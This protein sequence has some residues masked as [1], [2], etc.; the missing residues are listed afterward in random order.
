MLDISYP[1]GLAEDVMG[2]RQLFSKRIGRDAALSVLF[3]VVE[4]LFARWMGRWRPFRCFGKGIQGMLCA[5]GSWRSYADEL[6]I[7]DYNNI[8]HGFGR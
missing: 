3:Q 4:N 5:K 8:F 6:A 7:L 1:E 2:F